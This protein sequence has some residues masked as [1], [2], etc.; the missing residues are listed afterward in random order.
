VAE[1]VLKSNDL[2]WLYSYGTDLDQHLQEVHE[3]LADT[4]AGLAR[5]QL[6]QPRALPVTILP[7]LPRSLR[8]RLLAYYHRQKARLLCLRVGQAYLGQ[9]NLLDGYLELY[10]ANGAYRAVALKYLLKARDIE[11]GLSPHAAAHYL[12]DEGELRRDPQLLQR[13]IAALDPYWE[14][15]AVYQALVSLL[16][17]LR[18]QPLA[19]RQT[20]N[21]LYALNPGGLL[22][23]GHGLPL[24]LQVDGMPPGAAGLLARM[25][26]QAGSQV[27]AASAG[28]AR[29]E[30]SESGFRYLLSLRQVSAGL[31]VATLFDRA[32]SRQLFREAVELQRPEAR[33]RAQAVE[34]ARELVKR[35]Y[36]PR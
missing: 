13:S 25:L 7:A 8:Y 28:P 23:N 19:L 24:L 14:K 6:L 11:V 9:G 34:L 31:V 20:L 35:L 18:R 12:T 29:R 5:A 15:K 17:L 36:E 33:P 21:R 22:Q 16:P 27:Q 1:Q 30:P 3:I 4:Y 26:R 2:A 10:R 32:E